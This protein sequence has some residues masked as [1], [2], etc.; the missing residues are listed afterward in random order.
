MKTRSRGFTLV[1]LMIALIIVGTLAGLSLNM[2]KKSV[3]KAKLQEP[4]AILHA[5]FAQLS[6][7]Y[8]ENGRNYLPTNTIW[9]SETTPLPGLGF[10]LPGGK[11]RFNYV[12]FGATSGP[13]YAGV[14]Y[15]FANWTAPIDG[16][17]V[18]SAAAANYRDGLQLGEYYL[19]YMGLDLDG[20][21]YGWAPDGQP[22]SIGGRS[23]S[24]AR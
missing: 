5:L 7:Y 19:T 4:V 11:K 15:A 9:L 17:L 18:S 10:K 12:L 14:S 16:N 1:E 6:A 21:I 20:S 2:Y 23:P 22:L 3:R 8:Y 13:G 24:S